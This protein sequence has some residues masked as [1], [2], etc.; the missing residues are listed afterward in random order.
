VNADLLKRDL[1][2]SPPVDHGHRSDR[3]GIP[4]PRHARATYRR[5]LIT[6]SSALPDSE[7]STIHHEAQLT[8]PAETTE[9]AENLIPR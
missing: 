8:V 3:T 6:V 7:P 9:F 4:V 1:Y 5:D 2:N